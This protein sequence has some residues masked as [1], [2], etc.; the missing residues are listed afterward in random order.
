MDAIN[1]QGSGG[2]SSMAAAS[3]GNKKLIEFLIRKGVSM[4]TVDMPEQNCLF[5]Q[6]IHTKLVSCLWPRCRFN[7]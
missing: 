6:L 3:S 1:V 5:T 4:K 2:K 7:A